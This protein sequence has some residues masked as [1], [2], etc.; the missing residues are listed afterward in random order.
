M[1]VKITGNNQ[2]YLDD[3]KNGDLFLFEQEPYLKIENNTKEFENNCLAVHL[4][5]GA[6]EEFAYTEIVIFPKK[7]LLNIEV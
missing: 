2:T 5:T 1:E 3:L 4:Q 7:S 6:I